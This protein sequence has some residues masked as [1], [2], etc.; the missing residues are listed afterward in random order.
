MNWLISANPEIYDHSSSFEHY[1]FIDWRQGNFSFEI[2]DI[3]YIYCTRPI[4][5]IRYKSVVTIKDMPFQ[6]IRDDKEYWLNIN[7]YEK[8]K[9]GK[10]MRLKLI[11]QIDS[12]RMNLDV[13]LNNGLNAAPQGPIKLK[14]NLLT[15]IEKNF[16]D[17]NQSEVFPEMIA[18]DAPIYEGLKKE[19]IVNKY[20]RSSIARAKCIEAKG[21]NCEI[22]DMKFENIYGKL[23]KDFIHIHHIIPLFQIN[24]TYK[25]DYQK[26]LIPVC[27]NCH[28]M[29]HKKINAKEITVDEL[30]LIIKNI[31]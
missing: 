8:A 12:S 14:G 13:L 19:I 30:K 5:S 11:E 1:S 17:L 27:P 20:E 26:D 9:T 29:L 4:S 10:Y 6:N 23:G 21:Y 24:E 28:A 16:S 3:V 15:Y 22:C 25:I 2:K 18:E 7:E 31:R